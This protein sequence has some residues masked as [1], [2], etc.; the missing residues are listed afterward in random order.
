MEQHLTF[1]T[2]FNNAKM[3]LEQG[4][5]S[6]FIAS[7]LHKEGVDPATIS[8]VLLHLKRL[9]NSKRTQTGSRLVLLGVIL[10]GLGFLS[11]CF[12]LDPG[13]ALTFALYGLTSIGAVTLVA[14]LAM[15]FS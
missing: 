4:H 9:R 8:E 2:H 1:D 12:L 13:N 7:H 10:M 3:M 14:G 5:E 6:D 11:C 15:I